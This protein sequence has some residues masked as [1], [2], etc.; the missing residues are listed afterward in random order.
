MDGTA[1]WGPGLTCVQVVHRCLSSCWSRG[2]GLWISI[3]KCR[4]LLHSHAESNCS[5]GSL[6]SEMMLQVTSGSEI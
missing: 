6:A 5:Q 3:C 1:C 4:C 2:E